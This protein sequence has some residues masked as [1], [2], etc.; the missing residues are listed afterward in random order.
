VRGCVTFLPVGRSGKLGATA[1]NFSSLPKTGKSRSMNLVNYCYK[2]FHHEVNDFIVNRRE[3]V[4]PSHN[5]VYFRH[6]DVFRFYLATS[7][8]TESF[9]VN[10][11]LTRITPIC[12]GL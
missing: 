2:P 11:S 8:F 7:I 10:L 4:H 6:Y 12:S 9:G 1:G 5:P 3:C